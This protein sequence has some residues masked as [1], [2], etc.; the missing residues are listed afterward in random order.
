MKL[1]PHFHELLTGTVNLPP[2]KLGQLEERVEAIYAA[3]T[4]DDEIGDLITSKDPQGSWAQRTIIRPRPSREFDADF[5][6]IM[7]HVQDWDDSPK[8]YID[9]V[10]KALRS[11]G[12]YGKLDPT[13][14]CR[15]VRLTYAND[16]HVD[17]VPLVNHPFHGKAIVNRDDDQWES[18]YPE[19]FTDWM[20][21]KDT[22]AEGNLRRVIRL[23]K[24]V[25]DH[26]SNFTA[27]K[28][29]ILTTLLG[30]GVNKLNKFTDPGYYTSTATALK[31]IVGDLDDWLQDRPTRPSIAVPGNPGLT[32]DHRW[33]DDNYRYFRDR[34]N[35]LAADI[36][37]AHDEEDKEESIRLWRAI[38]GDGF[39]APAKASASGRFGTA[40]AVVGRSGRG[41]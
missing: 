31:H 34:I 16:F 37:A 11:H 25:R 29:I 13:R 3:L 9:A 27:T 21:D 1:D 8:Q 24:Y 12:T 17:I 18:S 6:L 5:M 41:G 15:C 26:R 22:I 23:M 4:A 20:H 35:V 30:G 7:A 36:V 14:K 10:S 19:G 2:G 32:F 38:F 40:A 33:T 39:R 28:S